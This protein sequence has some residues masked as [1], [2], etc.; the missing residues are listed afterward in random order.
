MML[1]MLVIAL[2]SALLFVDTKLLGKYSFNA[3][4]ST[5][6]LSH[7]STV[8][9]DIVKSRPNLPVFGNVL[10]ACQRKVHPAHLPQM[11]ELI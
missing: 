3:M 9:A 8:S 4:S 2:S 11:K 1:N 5:V 7:D 6:H 10:P